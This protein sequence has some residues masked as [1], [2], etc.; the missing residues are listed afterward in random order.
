MLITFLSEKMRYVLL[1][2]LA[3]VGISF[4]FFGQWT[5]SGPWGSTLVGTINGHD[6]NQY[7]FQAQASASEVV[8]AFRT[9]RVLGRDADETII[10]QTWVRLLVLNAAREAGLGVPDTAIADAIKNNPLFQDEG[11]YSPDLFQKFLQHYLSPKRIDLGRFQE[12]IRDEL[13]IQ[14]MVDTVGGTA[15]VSPEE[16]EDTLNRLYGECQVALVRFSLKQYEKQVNPT[17][18]DLKKFY[19]ENASAYLTPEKR[20]I[21]YIR[22]ALTPE[23]K[24]LEGDEHKQALEQLEERAFAFADPFLS[25]D[26]DD[27][28]SIAPDFARTCE[29]QGL[30][31]YTTKPF[32][33]TESPIEGISPEQLKRV[34]FDLS[35]ANPVSDYL[36]VEDGFMVCKLTEIIE[37]QPLPFE[38]VEK[39]LRK[40]Y[41]A[42]RS[43]ERIREDVT[44]KRTELLKAINAGEDFA[45]AAK[46]LGLK[47]ETPAPFAPAENLQD[48]SKDPGALVIRFIAQRLSQGELSGFEPTDDGG[49]LVHL[50]SRTPTSEEKKSQYLPRVQQQLASRARN[51]ILD[52]WLASLMLKPETKVPSQLLQSQSPSPM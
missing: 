8:Y 52:D 40:T 13:L 49:L 33:A 47:V 44:A 28:T 45:K 19:E 50:T 9:G 18:E 21:Q 37:P 29:S 35:A 15:I 30:R 27:P 42:Q 2:L 5:P 11:D 20:S 7:E 6:I 14:A 32:P 34:V 36:P 16:A 12:I 23:Q 22:L 10:N 41:I 26:P 38:S 25:V 39:D 31:L 43:R 48:A 17:P 3:L 51:Q 24:K 4:I 1:G 46:K